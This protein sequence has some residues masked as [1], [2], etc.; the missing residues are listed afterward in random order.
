MYFLA[1]PSLSLPVSFAVGV[2]CEGGSV[3]VV[4]FFRDGVLV[5][6]LMVLLLLI[7]YVSLLVL[8]HCDTS[9]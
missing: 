7:D 4:W 5:A 3:L 1:L 2:T 9:G 8:S 6:R